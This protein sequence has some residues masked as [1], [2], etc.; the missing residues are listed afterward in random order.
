M[1]VGGFFFLMHKLNHIEKSDINYMIN[2]REHS[3]EIFVNTALH[4]F[5]TKVNLGMYQTI[6]MEKQ[7]LTMLRTSQF[8]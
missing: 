1:Y 2:P 8:D 4:M 3:G 6:M 5:P 7:S